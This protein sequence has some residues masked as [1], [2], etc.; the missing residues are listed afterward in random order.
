MPVDD[1]ARLMEAREKLVADL[2]LSM[3]P[4]VEK[5]RSR[6]ATMKHAARDVAVQGVGTVFGGA[7][8]A[9]LAQIVGLLPSDPHLIVITVV[10]TLGLAGAVLSAVLGLT[11]PPIANSDVETVNRIEQID[12][13]IATLDALE[14]GP[15]GD[16]L[17]SDSP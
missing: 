11:K 8:L 2:R 5:A 12:G 16:P 4:G 1:R 7:V 15:N 17:T 10:L 13:A 9:L 6:K 3:A 14:H